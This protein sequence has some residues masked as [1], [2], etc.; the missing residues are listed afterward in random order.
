M[1][2]DITVLIKMHQQSLEMHRKMDSRMKELE[3]SVS[4]GFSGLKK[5]L[6]ERAQQTFSFK[7]SVYEVCHS[8][9]VTNSAAK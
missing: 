6:D 9:H 3:K 1:I 7:D 2:D 8:L 4:E 5:M